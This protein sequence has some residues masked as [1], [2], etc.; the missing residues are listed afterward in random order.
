MEFKKTNKKTR[1]LQKTPLKNGKTHVTTGRTYLPYL[2][3]AK[4][5]YPETYSQLHNRTNYPINRCKN[6]N[7][8]TYRKA[9]WVA[10]EAMKRCSTPLAV[11]K[12]KVTPQR[13][14]CTPARVA[15]M[16]KAEPEDRWGW[17]TP[18]LF[19]MSWGGREIVQSFWETVKKLIMKLNTILS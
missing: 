3:L 15:K 17:G 11:R 10:N 7:R 2:C 1:A 9:V 19:N 12:F 18:G 14:C 8:C 13:C 6:L 16:R 5:F 4:N